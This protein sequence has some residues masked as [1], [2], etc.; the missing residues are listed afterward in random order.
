MRAVAEDSRAPGRGHLARWVGAWFVWLCASWIAAAANVSP[1][2][3]AARVWQTDEGLPQ[4]SVRAIA[5]TQDGYLWVG[6]EDGM[7]CF[8]GVRFTPLD[9]RVA[10]E[11]RHGYIGALCA[12]RDGS[13]WIACDNYGVLRLKDGTITRLTETDGLPSNTNRCLFESKDGALWICSESG[14]TRYKDGK[15]TIFAEKHGLA[16]NSVRG[17]TQDD[18][19]NLRVATRRGL[20][21]MSPE[22]VVLGTTITFSPTWPGNALRFISRDSHGNIWTGSNDGLTEVRDDSQIFYGTNQTEK[23]P[24]TIVNAYCEDSSGQCWIGTYAGLAR[25]V[26]GKIVRGTGSEAVY[27]DRI[28]TIFEDREGNVW[29]GAKDGL[30]RLNPAR[31]RTYTS[32]QGLTENNIMSVCA[33]RNGA[34]WVATWGG[35]LDQLKD[36]KITGFREGLT[37][38]RVLALHE[39]TDGSLWIGMESGGGLDRF[40]NGYTNSFRHNGTLARD[41]IRVIHEDRQGGLWIGSS[42]K[43]KFWRNNKVI[44]YGTGQG[45]PNETIFA[46]CEDS[47][48]NLWVGTE[49]GLSR[50]DGKSFT[51]FG[52]KEGLSNSTVTALYE[53]GEHTL[54]IGTRAGGLNQYRDGKFSACTT[55]QGL[56]SDEIYEIIEDEAGYFWMSCRNGIFRVARKELEELHRGARKAVTCTVFGKSDGLLSKQCNGVAKPAACKGR[57]GR[58]WFPTI[59][60]VVSVET[61][62]KVNTNV[63]PVFIDEVIGEKQRLRGVLDRWLDTRLAG[64]P[65]SGKALQIPSG[66][67]DVEIRYTALSLQAP[68]KNRF[69]YWLEGADTG[70][71]DAGTERTARYNNLQ[72]GNYRF[73]VIGCNNDGVWND[74]G[75]T[76]AFVILPHY[77]QTWWFRAA[78]VAGLGLLLAGAYRTRVARLRALEALRVQIAANLHDD[79][80]A[81]LTK[82]AMVTESVERETADSSQLHPHIRTIARTTRE[83]IRAM[84][85]IV[86]TINPQNDTLDNLANYIFSYAQEYFQNTD[87]RCRMDVPAQL[88]NQA[89]STEIRH[90]LFMAVKEAFNN[91]LKHSKA[92][93]VQVGLT[94]NDG[95]MTISIAD[96]GR[97]FALDQKRSGGNGL[98][99]MRQRLRKIGGR[100]TI[101]S[102]PG[103]GT[104][105]VMQA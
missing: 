65:G 86:W 13:L 79:V 71:I 8:D 105:I 19:G 6:T 80:G 87:V 89:L 42:R 3:Y 74:Q 73:H 43:L 17:V 90:N 12:T 103:E 64:S 21:T 76:L 67:G 22:G 56:F 69:K 82:V 11:L 70:W 48:G 32:Q 78:C 40:K 33:D 59:R 94:L 10:P 38:D 84:D 60:G 92:S 53:D 2:P 101:E 81:R 24:S 85:E 52:T 4:I 1:M 9:E 62:I 29:V 27:S 66:R 88:P 98:D 14:L 75:A 95:R 100:L 57:D 7:A 36:G 28:Y 104:R 44:E 18:H 83:I 99:N 58:L 97:G 93:E 96:N 45:L 23:L 20:S 47:A 25:L 68:E 34:I 50:W 102:R 26:N 63:P 54:W 5:Q 55:A 39:G 72:H 46:L 61:R 31:F 41:A 91:V 16:D 15:I 30:Y 37:D 49:N 35:G 51:N 77:W